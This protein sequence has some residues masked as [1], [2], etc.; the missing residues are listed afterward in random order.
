MSEPLAIAPGAGVALITLFASDGTLLAGKSAELAVSL[1]DAGAASVLVAGTVGEYYALSDQERL[2]LIEAVRLA[3]PPEIPVI[4]HVGGV[5]AER[6]EQLASGA[7]ACGADA[8]IALAR[9]IGDLKA[10]Y[11]RISQASG[12]LPLL[13]YHLPQAGNIVEMADLPTLGVRAIKDSSGEA[14]RLAMEQF[15]LD[16]E[17]YT[18]SA[19]LLGLAHDIGAAGALVGLANVHPELCVSAFAGDSDAQRTLARVGTGSGRDFPGALKHLT[20]ERWGCAPYSRTPS[21]LSVGQV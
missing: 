1:V 9:E 2:V 20:A 8:L 10:F 14:G 19:N 11:A 15:T 5:P 21:G 6:A 3:V 18:G 12:G 4:A 16:L 7:A 13:A 17:V